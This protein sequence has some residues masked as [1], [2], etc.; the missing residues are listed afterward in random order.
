MC[1]PYMIS[2]KRY[3]RSSHGTCREKLELGLPSG[4]PG[5]PHATAGPRS[6]GSRIDLSSVQ[7]GDSPWTH[8]GLGRGMS[9][10]HPQ[11]S[12]CP[13]MNTAICGLNLIFFPTSTDHVCEGRSK[14]ETSALL[15]APAV[16]GRALLFRWNH[17]PI[18]KAQV[19]A[20]AW[21]RAGTCPGWCLMPLPPSSVRPSTHP[22][23][24]P[25]RA[26]SRGGTAPGPGLLNE[27]AFVLQTGD[28]SKADCCGVCCAEKQSPLSLT[29]ALASR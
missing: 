21:A 12:P 14:G 4:S 17:P 6:D 24:L 10:D 26:G 1:P 3:R 16:L 23:P 8:T 15:T 19:R 18:S 28:C 22:L 20:G 9:L 13:S 11:I 29:L 27:T 25:E 7:G 5:V 2:P